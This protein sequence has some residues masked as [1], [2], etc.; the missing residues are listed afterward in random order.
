MS[1]QADV[2]L[3]WAY[4]I[5]GGDI[6]AENAAEYGYDKKAH[7]AQ[8]ERQMA[9]LRSSQSQHSDQNLSEAR[10]RGK[11]R[12]KQLSDALQGRMEGPEWD[13]FVEISTRCSEVRRELVSLGVELD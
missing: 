7:A 4:C 6:Y 8:S 11:A 1:Q 13:A 9:R 2:Y 12:Y 3:N 5:G 10:E